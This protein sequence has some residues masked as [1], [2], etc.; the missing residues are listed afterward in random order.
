MARGRGGLGDAPWNFAEFLEN[1]INTFG[2]NPFVGTGIGPS[3]GDIPN[4]NQPSPDE[5]WEN[6]D[7]TIKQFMVLFSKYIEGLDSDDI[8]RIN[9]QN[10]ANRWLDQYNKY[11]NGEITLDELKSFESED[12]SGMDGWN[13]YFNGVLGNLDNGEDPDPTTSTKMEDLVDE[14]GQDVVD[15]AT[16]VFNTFKDKIADAATDPLGALKGILDAISSGGIPEKCKNLPDG[17]T[18]CSKRCWKDCVSFNILGGIPGIPLPPGVIDVG[19]YRDFE[20]GLKTIG[21]SVEEI[22][23]GEKS[24]SDVLDEL[25]EWAKRTLPSM[26]PDISDTDGVFDWLKGILGGVVGG[27]VF[28]KIEDQLSDIL[29]PLDKGTFDCASVNREGGMVIDEG[30]CEGCMDG[31]TPNED[32]QCVEGECPPEM[33]KDELTGD[34][35]EPLGCQP[36]GPCTTADGVGGRYNADCECIANVAIQGDDIRETDRTM[37][38]LPGFSFGSTPDDGGENKDPIQGDDIDDSD[39]EYTD[40]D[41]GGFDDD[42]ND[43]DPIKGL[44][45]ICAGPKPASGFALQTYERHCEGGSFNCDSQNRVTRDD[46]SCGPCKPGFSFDENFDQC[47]RDSEVTGTPPPETTET[48]PSGGGG[49]GG[50]GMG[51]GAFAPF[52]AGISYTPQTLPEIQASTQPDYAQELE[53]L[54]TRQLAKRGMFT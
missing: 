16:G 15:I 1:F 18:N 43:K 21:A 40:I 45:E 36:G 51:A 10:E 33:V 41:I 37:T 30:S 44:D 22:V 14:F 13:D 48:P 35:V 39:R 47:V 11:K 29:F 5:V 52:L 24:I 23:N 17:G 6:L 34:C 25:G 54:I 2:Y 20:N 7:P 9:R 31:F 28:A 19:T 50:G 46:G 3:E 38:E 27:L 32:G 53:S 49:G 42:D 12:L 8:D 4:V 26:L